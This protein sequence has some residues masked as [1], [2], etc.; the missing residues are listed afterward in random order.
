MQV[1]QGRGLTKVCEDLR[2]EVEPA[3]T[4]ST[5]SYPKLAVS[6]KFVQSESPTQSRSAVHGLLLDD[7]LTLAVQLI[8]AVREAQA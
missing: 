3:E 7:A 8:E 5:G 2:T 1:V 4:Y 6:V